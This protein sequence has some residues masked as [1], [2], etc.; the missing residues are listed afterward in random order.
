MNEK[1]NENPF[2]AMGIALWVNDADLAP[3][4]YYLKHG[5][6]KVKF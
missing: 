6:D 5:L 1:S 2:S 3:T 4:F